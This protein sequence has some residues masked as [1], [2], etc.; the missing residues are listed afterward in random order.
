MRFLAVL[1]LIPVLAF[2]LAF[3]MFCWHMGGVF[4]YGALLGLAIGAYQARPKD[5][6][7]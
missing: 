2:G 1:L 4:W 7:P 6:L 3:L 5:V